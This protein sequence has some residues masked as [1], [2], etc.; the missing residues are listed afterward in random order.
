[1]SSDVIFHGNGGE[2]ARLYGFMIES[3]RSVN[4][5]GRRDPDVLHTFI[6][7]HGGSQ[8]LCRFSGKLI[9]CQDDNISDQFEICP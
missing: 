6:W 7:F 8:E 1:M 4:Q 2:C 5:I 3:Q 9:R